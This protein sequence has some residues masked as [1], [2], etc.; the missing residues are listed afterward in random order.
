MTP[1]VPQD[2]ARHERGQQATAV[3]SRP[4]TYTPESRRMREALGLSNV[5]CRR[6]HTAFLFRL[7]PKVART[8]ESCQT[9]ESAIDAE[10]IDLMRIRPRR[11]RSSP[12]FG[13]KVQERLIDGLR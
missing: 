9:T 4:T 6:L 3:P 1:G 7:S 2:V 10:V 8:H 13:E 5:A 12:E 11:M